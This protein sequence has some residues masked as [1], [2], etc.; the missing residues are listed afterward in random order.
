MSLLLFGLSPMKNTEA[1]VFNGIM[2]IHLGHIIMLDL[3]LNRD[4]ETYFN[5]QLSK[6]GAVVDRVT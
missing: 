5:V 6:N 4:K 2:F 1:F 3:S